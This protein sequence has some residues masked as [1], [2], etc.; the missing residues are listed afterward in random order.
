[1]CPGHS[2]KYHSM[3]DAFTE[4]NPTIIIECFF[5]NF[6][7]RCFRFALCLLYL[8]D[9]DSTHT[10]THAGAD[11]STPPRPPVCSRN[12]PT[13]RH[14]RCSCR[15]TGVTSQICLCSGQKSDSK[16]CMVSITPTL[17]FTWK[18]HLNYSS[19]TV[20]SLLESGI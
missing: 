9:R 16:S 2:N 15:L 12:N 11:G 19:K 7:D 6:I 17:S 1:M 13:N 4:V 3:K 8:T 10:H 18:I 14:V 20:C 5:F